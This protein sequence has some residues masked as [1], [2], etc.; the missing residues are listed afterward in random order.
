[1]ASALLQR[2]VASDPANRQ[3]ARQDCH[4]TTLKS[5]NLGILFLSINQLIKK[6]KD[7]SKVQNGKTL[8]RAKPKSLRGMEVKM[9][10][11]KRMRSEAMDFRFI[12]TGIRVKNMGESIRFY[13]E[14]LGMEIAEKRE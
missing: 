9:A 14:V 8:A 1:V 4:K 5:I 6:G 10:T 12:F 2:S 11:T 13:T 3:N 7:M